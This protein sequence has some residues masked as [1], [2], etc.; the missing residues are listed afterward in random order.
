MKIAVNDILEMLQGMPLT[1]LD[2]NAECCDLTRRLDV[3]EPNYYYQIRL[4]KTVNA[5]KDTDTG[6]TLVVYKYQSWHKI[7]FYL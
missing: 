7:H 4:H 2:E 3:L 5:L 1:Y 6:S